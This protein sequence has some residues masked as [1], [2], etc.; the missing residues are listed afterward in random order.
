MP[1]P[2]L[3]RHSNSQSTNG[4]T[5]AIAVTTG[6]SN[7]I[8]LVAT[9]IGSTTTSTPTLTIA[10]AGLTWNAL[11]A[12][13]AAS[14]AMLSGFGC[15]LQLWWAIAAAQLTS[16]TVTITSSI[17]ID[18]AAT[19]YASFTGAYAASPIDPNAGAVPKLYHN[20]AATSPTGTFSSTNADDVAV[21]FLGSNAN[22]ATGWQGPATSLDSAHNIAGTR[23]ATTDM[24][25]QS[26]TAAQ[27]NVT[28]TA[29][30][31]QTV[32]GTIGAMLTA[33]APVGGGAVQARVLVMA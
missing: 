27:T 4:T 31:S 25:Y 14:G 10:G 7:T 3:D 32:W 2:V 19:V 22:L 6:A 5:T 13:Y 24:G 12:A 16:Q 23:W 33:D 11:D 28:L 9:S 8:V 29:G 20:G 26:F 15:A 21:V 1:A 17:T 30:G 18:G